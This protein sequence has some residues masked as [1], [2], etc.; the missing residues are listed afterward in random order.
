MKRSPNRARQEKIRA[1]LLKMTTWCLDARLL[2][3]LKA[4]AAARGT[5]MAMLLDEAL[6][7][8]LQRHTQGSSHEQ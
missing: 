2:N 3:R 8:Y 7:H 1:G 5:S 4:A 6:R